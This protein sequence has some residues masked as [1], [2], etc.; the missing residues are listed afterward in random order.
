[1]PKSKR[2]GHPKSKTSQP[3]PLMV[4][5]AG[6]LLLIVAAFFVF[7]G[8]SGSSST[9]PANF[10]PEASGGHLKVDR[11]SVDLGNV[12]LGKTVQVAFT[13]TNTGDRTL[14]F[15]EAPYIDVKEGC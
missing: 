14:K 11:D 3:G 5:L 1:M 12:P 13:L 7:R 8:N 2:Y 9:P 6:A 10:T 15:T 4:V